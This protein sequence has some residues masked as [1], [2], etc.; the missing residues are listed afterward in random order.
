MP[1][2]ELDATEAQAYGPMEDGPY[3]VVIT[4]VSDVKEGPKASYITVVFT[5]SEG[6]HEGRQIWNNYMVSGK[7]AGMF[8]EFW[9]KCTGDALSIG[10]MHS[11]DTDE[12][13]STELTAI[14]TME[15]FEGVERPNIKR[16]LSKR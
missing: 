8:L 12:L 5:V 7:A 13:L 4:D 14:V 6:D 9:E 16:V 3:D 2:I 11:I 10:E 1:E 15:E